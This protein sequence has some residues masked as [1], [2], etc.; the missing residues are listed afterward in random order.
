MTDNETFVTASE[1]TNRPKQKTEAIDLRQ[2]KK[3]KIFQ[4][5]QTALRN[6]KKAA[7]EKIRKEKRKNDRKQNA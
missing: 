7:K 6:K 1:E 3:S 2:Q 5:M 4:R